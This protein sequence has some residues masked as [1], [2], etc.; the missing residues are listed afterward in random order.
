MSDWPMSSPQIITMLGFLFCAD[1]GIA[2]PTIAIV[3]S[4]TTVVSRCMILISLPF[5]LLPARQIG[6]G[7]GLYA[8]KAEVI[9]G[10][11]DFALSSRAHHIARAILVRA[12]KRSA[13]VNFLSLGGL[14]GIVGR[15]GPERIADHACGCR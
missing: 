11:A 3:I 9:G 7:Y 13:T 6:H 2:A 10:G 14:S 12:Q 1:A 5:V 8:P 15:V 4:T